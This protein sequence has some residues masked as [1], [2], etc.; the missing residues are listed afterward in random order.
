MPPPSDKKVSILIASVAYGGSVWTK[1]AQ[2]LAGTNLWLHT[3]PGVGEVFLVDPDRAPVA[4]AR[5]EVA[6]TALKAGADLTVM[7]D[8]DI[9]PAQNWLPAVLREYAKAQQLGRSAAVWAAPAI[10]S[11]GRTN[12]ADWYQTGPEPIEGALELHRYSAV[13]GAQKRG[14]VQVAAAGTGAIA[15]DTRVFRQV[16]KLWFALEYEDD[17]EIGVGTGED[18]YFTR[19]CS[20]QGIPVFVT[21]DQW[22]KHRKTVVLDRPT[23]VHPSVIPTRYREIWDAAQEAGAAS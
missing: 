8:H 21:W 7:V 20:E 14:I 23:G 19:S 9:A 10:C 22:A 11:D 1:H 6:I 17:Y 2:W 15:I 13:E 4:A 12:A 18:I 5:N 3:N 16:S